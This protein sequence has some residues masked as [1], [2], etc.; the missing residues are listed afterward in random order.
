M[1]QVQRGLN[2]IGCQLNVA[3]SKCL[4]LLRPLPM[5][6]SLPK[7]DQP[8]DP[9]QAGPVFWT[10]EPCVSLPEWADTT[11]HPML[12]VSHLMHLGHQLP[13]YM[14]Q[15]A[16][17]KNIVDELLNQLADLNAHPIQML[18]RVLLVN[19]VVL[20][21]LLY[22]CECY[23]L[24]NTQLQELSSAMERFVLAVSGLL[25]LVAKKTL[26]TH[27][28]RG[29]GLGCLQIL[30]PTRV[31]DSLHRNPLLDTLRVSSPS[32][33]SPRALF[34]RALSLLRPPRTLSM[35]PLTVSWRSRKALRGATE[36]A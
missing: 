14:A 33:I 9:V 35:L 30:Y 2:L 24:T 18:D 3:K 7:Y 11:E 17:Y 8:S 21:N 6:P 13:A 27:R 34:G 31:L 15:T 19:T 16:G 23:L 12:R 20:P 26:Y 36:I 4:P 1:S 5:P 22:R 29:L 10:V 32:H 28:S 25:S